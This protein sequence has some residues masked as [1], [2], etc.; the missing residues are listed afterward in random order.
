[1]PAEAEAPPGRD[2][3]VR[4]RVTNTGNTPGPEGIRLT[5][6]PLDEAP[7]PALLNRTDFALAGGESAFPTLRVSVPSGAPEGL[8]QRWGIQ[9]VATA[10]LAMAN[11]TVTATARHTCGIQW[12]VGQA[13][14]ATPGLPA[15]RQLWLS[16]LGTG[17][18]ALHLS[19]TGLPPG[20]AAL[21]VQGGREVTS[22]WL[23]PS[24]QIPLE[25]QVIPDRAAEPGTTY[26]QVVAEGDACGVATGPVTLAVRAVRG[27]SIT[28][29]EAHTVAAPGGFGELVLNVTNVGNGPAWIRVFTQGLPTSFAP[30]FDCGGEFRDPAPVEC[31]GIRMEALESRSVTLRVA[32]PH[33]STLTEVPFA[34]WASTDGGTRAS[35]ALMLEVVRPNLAVRDERFSPVRPA[36]GEPVVVT[37]TVANTG[38]GPSGPSRVLFSVD[39]VLAG[40]RPIDPLDPGAGEILQ[41]TW[42]AQ[43]GT[44][45]LEVRVVHEGDVGEAS[46]ADNLR[47]MVV[48]VVPAVGGTDRDPA[49]GAGPPAAPVAG[50]AAAALL[51]TALVAILALRRRSR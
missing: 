14:D 7:W 4:L 9:A 32:A 40:D 31:D 44:H 22:V 42:G 43:V 3:T 47:S 51:A 37:I 38:T 30:G 36:A 26:L 50:A 6:T 25:L 5:A 45:R 28:A 35:V 10:R 23:S 1:M 18:S 21:F 19:V 27:A 15:V 11:A 39:G 16:N 34:A 41:F 13:G 20:W 33:D 8:S 17:W 12:T 49:G 24:E 29:A 46:A 48:A 2:V